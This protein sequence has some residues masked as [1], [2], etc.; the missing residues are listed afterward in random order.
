[1][2]FRMVCISLLLVPGFASRGYNSV[3]SSDVSSSESTEDTR[4]PRVFTNCIESSSEADPATPVSHG[5]PPVTA[6]MHSK[7]AQN[8][9]DNDLTLV[10]QRDSGGKVQYKCPSCNNLMDLEERINQWEKRDNRRQATN[11]VNERFT[12]L[13]M[14]CHCSYE[15]LGYNNFGDRVFFLL[16]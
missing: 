6:D 2:M 14:S 3:N 11:Q 12:T 9:E 15:Y 1:M 5:P 4:V 8:N 16:G 13:C 7:I 10:P